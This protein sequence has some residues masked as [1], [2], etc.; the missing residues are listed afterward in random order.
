MGQTPL[1]YRPT[2]YKMT[3][4]EVALGKKPGTSPESGGEPD[5]LSSLWDQLSY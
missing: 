5:F 3:C 4:L 2:N 1:A